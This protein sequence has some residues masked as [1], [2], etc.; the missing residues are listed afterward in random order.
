[1]LLVS[2]CKSSMPH[3]GV[4]QR[5]SEID[6]QDRRRNAKDR[7][8]GDPHDKVV[9][10]IEDGA[11]EQH[12]QTGVTEDNFGNER[13]TENLTQGKCQPGDLWQHGIANDVFADDT[14]FGNTAQLG[15][16]NEAFRIDILNKQFHC[17]KDDCA[18]QNDERQCWQECVPKDI[19]DV[20]PSE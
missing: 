2:F 17:L 1:M 6:D 5:I 14:I 9:V 12:P 10:A 8:N 20:V 7:K 4:E 3:S 15:V 11:V 16:L 18:A 13:A 19:L